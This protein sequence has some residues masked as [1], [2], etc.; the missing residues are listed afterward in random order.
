[1][2]F[3]NRN[4]LNMPIDVSQTAINELANRP[5]QDINGQRYGNTLSDDMFAIKNPSL[6]DRHT[7]QS[8]EYFNQPVVERPSTQAWEPAAGWG[9]LPVLNAGL[10]SRKKNVTGDSLPW[11]VYKDW[12]LTD[13][14]L[15]FP[16]DYTQEQVAYAEALRDRREAAQRV[17]DLSTEGMMGEKFGNVPTTQSSYRD[18]EYDPYLGTN[19]NYGAMSPE[20]M[21]QLARMGVNRPTVEDEESLR[22]GENGNDTY[23]SLLNLYRLAIEN[24]WR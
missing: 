22:L 24:G 7:P 6:P 16:D 13:D 14:I 9:P 18:A 8:I 15:E 12:G 21:E 1:M 23:N 3:G 11:E 4:Q 17:N 19:V 2:P 5:R 10:V 20:T